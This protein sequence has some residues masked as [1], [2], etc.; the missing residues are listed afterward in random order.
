M[1]TPLSKLAAGAASALYFLYVVAGLQ[2]MFFSYINANW[3]IRYYF[4][5]FHASVSCLAAGNILHCGSVYGFRITTAATVGFL[6]LIIYFEELG[7]T[8]GYIF[9]SYGFTDALGPRISPNLPA[10]VPVMWMGLI[11]P[12]AL[13]SDVVIANLRD[14]VFSDNRIRVAAKVIVSS[15]SLAFFDIS[16]E[17]V[18]VEFGHKVN[19]TFFT[20]LISNLCSFGITFRLSRTTFRRIS[21][22]LTGCFTTNLIH[23]FSWEFPYR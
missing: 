5:S 15:F 23:L 16:T 2:L 13:L 21:P 12:A 8:T 14:G 22:S 19:S 4:L 17:P 10:L 6:V 3:R 11:Y 20:F 1:S 7:L 9:G 18:S